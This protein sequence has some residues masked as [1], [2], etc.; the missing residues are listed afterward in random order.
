[1]KIDAN[2]ECPKCKNAFN[3]VIDFFIGRLPFTRLEH[4]FYYTCI[5]CSSYLQVVG[6]L[7][8]DFS[9]KVNSIDKQNDR[10]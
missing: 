6:R 2:I 1:M 3:Q 7:K 5:V 8:L 4:G 9:F 10:I